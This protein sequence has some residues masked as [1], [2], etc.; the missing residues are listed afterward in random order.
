MLQLSASSGS[1]LGA[2]ND[3]LHDTWFAVSE[4]I[5]DQLSRTVSIH[6]G[7]STRESD[8]RHDSLLLVI[9]GV[10]SCNIEDQQKIDRYD[11]DQVQ[12]DASRGKLRVLTTIPTRFECE[13]TSLSLS[14]VVE[15]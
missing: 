10:S 9:G 11:I 12:Y 6:A 7:P 3:R 8:A 14:L 5:W 13:V 15:P 2:L 4:V 1:D